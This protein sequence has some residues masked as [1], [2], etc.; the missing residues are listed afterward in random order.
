MGIS[1]DNPRFRLL[2]G[3]LLRLSEFQNI[4]KRAN[5]RFVA[6][7]KCCKPFPLH[8]WVPQCNTLQHTATHCNTLQHKRKSKDHYSK[9]QLQ[10]CFR[11]FSFLLFPK[12]SHLFFPHFFCVKRKEIR[13]HSDTAPI[14]LFGLF[15]PLIF[16]LPSRTPAPVQI[17]TR[18]VSLNA[19]CIV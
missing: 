11:V 13:S 15:V 12:L 19:L 7:S 14:A 4:L 10:Y 17:R 2:S 9:R 1:G 6:S 5:A 18:Y 8:A 16:T 3:N